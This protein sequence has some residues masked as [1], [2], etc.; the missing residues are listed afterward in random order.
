[1][2]SFYFSNSSAVEQFNILPILPLF[3]FIAID[4][5]FILLFLILNFFFFSSFLL[6]KDFSFDND[7]Y[8]LYL[9]PSPFQTILEQT[10]KGG[11]SLTKDNI[12]SKNSQLYFPLVSILFVFLLSANIFGLVPYSYT[13]TS[14]LIVTLS[15]SLSLF[16]GLNI[17][18]F[19]QYKFKMFRLFLPGGT[20]IGL[21]FVLVPIEFV[22]YLFKPISLAIRLFVNTMAGHTL[23]KVI[24]GFSWS[25]IGARNLLLC[26]FHIFPT[27]ILIPLFF[28]ETAVAV[29][30]A[31]VFTVLVCI[32][33]N[34]ALNL[35]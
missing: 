14:H 1:M 8:S 9:I 24:A 3:K 17:I 19:N 12:N 15:L 29:I 20:Q 22:L 30:Q 28:L 16:I 6:F 32:Y 34:D 13:V 25:L 27:I 33:L 26:I 7:S 2:S 5:V 21:A 31:F 4:N 18:C 10:F 11:L 35:Y 23:L